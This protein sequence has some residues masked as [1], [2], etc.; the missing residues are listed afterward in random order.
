[1]LFSLASQASLL[2]DLIGGKG[3]PLPVEEAYLFSAID[4]EPGRY[5]LNW[6][7][8]ENYY[9]YRDKIKLKV[10]DN[11]EIVEQQASP[12]KQKED[13]L[14]GMVWVYYEQADLKVAI[15]SR[16]GQPASGTLS[17]E[18]QGCWE[19][20]ICYPP[21]TKK[22]ELTAIPPDTPLITAEPIAP[23]SQSGPGIESTGLSLT[24][25]QPYIAALGS[26]SWWLT[27]SLFF[28]AGLAL[29]LTPCVFPMIPI[30]SGVIAGQGQNITTGKALRLSV[31]YVLAMSLTYTVAGVVAGL[32]GENLQ[33]AF[34]NAW[35]IGFFSILFVLLALSMFG[36]YELQMPHSVQ[37]ALNRASRSQRGGETV[38]VAIMG[39]LSALVVGPC[40]AAPLAGALV[41]I[42]QTGDPYL[43]GGALFVLSLGM[44]A[45][46]ILVGT[47]AGKWLPKSGRWMNAIKS[48]FGVILLLMA[49]WMLDRVVDPVVTM[50]LV[51]VVLVVTAIYLRALDSLDASANGWQRLGKGVGILLLI[52]GGS[53]LVGAAAGNRSLITPLQG[54]ATQGAGQPVATLNFAEVTSSN[55]LDPLL[56][57]AHFEG[58]PVM[59]DFYA[60]W[61]VSCKELEFI[62]FADAGVQ[63][64][65][66]RY[67]LIRVDVTAHDEAAKELYRRYQ[68]IGPPALI[69]YDTQGERQDQMMVIGVPDSDE[70]TAHL[71]RL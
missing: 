9:L 62:T 25:Q 33:A 50:V 36:F 69:F 32:F 21:V 26:G 22:V 67:S 18:Y 37:N 28:V 30:L 63:Q 60:D 34:Q 54:V 58:R 17:V 68:I 45:P 13:P 7:I 70:F 35:M 61:C 47:S 16:T 29:A 31:I 23:V 6:L 59:L 43:G 51:A 2:S 24:D 10:S 27:L 48:T 11:L 40:V 15:R 5:E 20:G 71:Q 19:G 39:F 65:M 64:E 52:Y 46:V 4:T 14:F 66:N 53:L 12:A 3:G 8:H 41:Y 57:Q 55:E 42:G 44:G 49:V 56:E 38:G 1:M